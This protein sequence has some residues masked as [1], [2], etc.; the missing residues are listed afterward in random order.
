MEENS[1]D[2]SVGSAG[3]FSGR[4]RRR[5]TS[6]SVKFFDGLAKWVICVGG[7]GV[8]VAFAAIVFFLG[9]S[10]VPMFASPKVEKV[11]S[12]GLAWPQPAT[13]P[14][15][16]RPN[17]V[18]GLG[19]DENLSAVW[20]LASSGELACFNASTGKLVSSKMLA[21]SPLTAACENLGAIGLGFDNGELRVGRI[22]EKVEYLEPSRFPDSAESLQ[23][24]QTV[25]LDGRLGQLT[26]AGQLRLMS[27]E[28]DMSDPIASG[29]KPS[30]V[31]LVD[32]IRDDTAEKVAALRADGKLVFGTIT[33]KKNMMTG[34]VKR[35]VDMYDIPM[36]AD[37]MGTRPVKLLLGLNGRMLYLLYS[38]SGMVR[39][40]LDDPSKPIVAENRRLFSDAGVGISQA[41]MLLGQTTL[42]IAD[43][44]GGVSGWF[45]IKPDNRDPLGKDGLELVEAHELRP[46]GGSVTDIA[47]S[48]RDRQFLTTDAKGSVA[49]RHMTSGTTQYELQAEGGAIRK[50][51]FSPKVDAIL[52][53]GDDGRVVTYSLHNPH[54]D[55]S[56]SQMFGKLHY[57]GYPKAD[58]VYQSSSGTQDAEMKISLV[59][60]IFGTLKATFYAMLFAVP[61]AIMGAIYTSEFMSPHLRSVVKP[62]IELM[63]SLPSV[64]LGFIGALLLAPLVENAAWAV[65][66]VFIAVPVGLILLGMVWQLLPPQVTLGVPAGL[67]F[68]IMFATT[69]AGA[70]LTWSL[71]PAVEWL[72]FKQ[73]GHAPGFKEWLA[74]VPGSVG[75]PGWIVVLCPVVGVG[76]SMAFNTFLRPRIAAYRQQHHRIALGVTEIG[77]FVGLT[78]ATLLICWCLGVVLTH[79]WDLRGSLFGAYVQRN[80]LMVGLMMGFAIIPIIYTVSEDALGGVPSTL[81]SASLGAGATPWQ[82][83][84]RVVLPVAASGIFSA[85][86]IGFGRAAGETMIVLMLSGRTP[87]IDMNIFNGLSALSANIATEMPEAAVN[88]TH[89]RLLFMST[90]VLFGLTFIVNTAAEIVRLRFRKRAFQL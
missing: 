15:D 23:P 29:G 77:R 62:T 58:Y 54:A 34:K 89:Y 28:A 5:K 30:P 86:M 65:L 44:R 22:S 79:V 35:S 48:T 42:I 61:I 66:L 69:V 85:C 60:L 78:L 47:A 11:N 14:T 43:T 83:A 73:I 52:T 3:T 50:V 70:A 64:V 39:Y 68:T 75:T 6:P 40:G 37:R 53:L 55:G 59:P 82:T 32:Y 19:A 25:V 9:W 57:E 2:I 12:V 46:Q 1:G 81:R 76:L 80:S 31:V 45:P 36:P 38:D 51:A 72:L 74:R 17:Q 33:S 41:R 88:S 71:A 24:G 21:Q 56:M 87:I 26:P 27:I 49:L 16:A 7:V 8:T 18:L 20:V 4:A 10:V 84:I 13:R 67:K 90:L 63:A